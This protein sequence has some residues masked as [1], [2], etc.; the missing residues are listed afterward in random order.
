MTECRWYCVCILCTFQSRGEMMR[1][2]M[3][4]A[5]GVVEGKGGVFLVC[6]IIHYVESVCVYI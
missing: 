5:N 4:C 1:K 3:Y 6:E 2:W